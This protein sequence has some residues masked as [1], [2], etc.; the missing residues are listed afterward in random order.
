M[1]QDIFTD[2]FP[3]WPPYSFNYTGRNLPLSLSVA[4]QGTK[5][6]VV[7]YNEAVEIV[8]Q[9]TNV[10]GVG[11][12]HPM[13]LHG[14][15]FYLVGIGIGNFNNETDPKNFNLIDPPY[16]NTIGVPK[17]GWAAIRFRAINPGM[18]L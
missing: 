6:K 11:D 12:N 4:S 14:Y 5:V 13:H 18:F 1:E 17:N 3:D 7:N 9:G 16:V 10:G 8:F 15:N 2:D